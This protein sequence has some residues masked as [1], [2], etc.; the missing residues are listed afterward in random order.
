MHV[1][2]VLQCIMLMCYLIHHCCTCAQPWWG[3]LPGNNKVTDTLEW[4]TMED[5]KQMLEQLQN[6]DARNA[7]NIIPVCLVWYEMI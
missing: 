6:Y 2:T 1:C 7:E 5:R 3:L 4:E